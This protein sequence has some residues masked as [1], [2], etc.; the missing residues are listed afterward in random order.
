[1]K[2]AVVV[3]LALVGGSLLAHLLLDDPGYVAVR[4]GHTLFE[5]TLPAA[6]LVIFVRGVFG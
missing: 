2:P 1:V 6:L 4:A 3:A 5:T